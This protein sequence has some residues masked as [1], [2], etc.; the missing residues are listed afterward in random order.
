MTLT[1]LLGETEEETDTDPRIFESLEPVVGKSSV[2]MEKPR[3]SE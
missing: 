3:R 1:A 2:E